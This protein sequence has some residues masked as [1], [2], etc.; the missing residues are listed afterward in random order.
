MKRILILTVMLALLSVETGDVKAQ[1]KPGERESLKGIVSVLVI[2][3]VPKVEQHPPGLTQS[4]LQTSVELRL[5][6]AGVPIMVPPSQE[7]R[8]CILQVELTIVR[9]LDDP[10][11]A[12][13]LDVTAK[14]ITTLSRDRSITCLSTTWQRGQVGILGR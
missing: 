2:V 1:Q 9:M 6:K 4:D 13:G 12:Y 11:I 14:Q 3:Q 5:R 10:G 8:S 7:E